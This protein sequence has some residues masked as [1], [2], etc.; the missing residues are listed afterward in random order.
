MSEVTDFH[1]LDACPCGGRLDCTTTRFNRE[2][3]IKSGMLGGHFRSEWI[4]QKCGGVTDQYHDAHM[5]DITSEEAM[6]D[7]GD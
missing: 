1:Q 6:I 3:R 4:C 5:K 2:E 7:A